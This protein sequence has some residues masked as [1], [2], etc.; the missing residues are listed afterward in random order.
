MAILSGVTKCRCEGIDFVT[1]NRE[2]VYEF[3]GSVNV[4]AQAPWDQI[5]LKVP[6]SAGW[7]VRGTVK[8]HRNAERELAAS[9]NM[10]TAYIFQ[11]Y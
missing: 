8:F 10:N 3:E 9:V 2:S 1:L 5:H 7:K 4:I 6:K 11:L